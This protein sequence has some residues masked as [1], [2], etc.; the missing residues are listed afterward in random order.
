MRLQLNPDEARKVLA[1][2]D[3][4]KTDDLKHVRARL[5]EQIATAARSKILDPDEITALIWAAGDVIETV[6]RN[7]NPSVRVQAHAQ[8]LVTAIPK[9]EAILRNKQ[10]AGGM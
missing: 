1:Q 10:P 2:L 5:Q 9:L 6:R 8:Q 7:P 3:T 4:A